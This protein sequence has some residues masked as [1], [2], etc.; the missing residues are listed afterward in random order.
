[1]TTDK[2]SEEKVEKVQI[3]PHPLAKIAGKFKGE[4]WESTLKN[5]QNFRKREKEENNRFFDNQ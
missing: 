1:M 2:L 5:I 4:F 3:F